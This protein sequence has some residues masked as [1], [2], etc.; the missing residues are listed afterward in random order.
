VLRFEVLV[1]SVETLLT[2]QSTDDV[3]LYQ[4]AE[5]AGVPPASVYHF[6]PTKEAAFLALARRYLK[7]FSELTRRPVD[8]AALYSWQ[9][10]LAWDHA[11]AAAYYAE[12]PPAMKLFLGGFGG[13]ET[14]QADIE[15]NARAARNIYRRMNTA[16]HMPFLRDSEKKFH[17]NMEI[18]D[19]I[20]SLSYVKHSAVT[21]EYREEALNACVAYCRLFLP[22]RTELRDEHVQAIARGEPI[23]LHPPLGDNE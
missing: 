19:A 7:G 12:H 16:F 13:M 14:R 9:G 4:I 5:H 1:D 18:A 17:V 6:F 15:Y 22:E 23:V 2:D 11:L 10:L 21:E 8:P 3:G 20:W